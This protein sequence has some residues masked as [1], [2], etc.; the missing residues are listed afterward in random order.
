MV[1]IRSQVEAFSCRQQEFFSQ[2]IMMRKIKSCRRKN[3][4]ISEFSTTRATQLCLWTNQS[5]LKKLSKSI[6]K[7]EDFRRLTSSRTMTYTKWDLTL[8]IADTITG[9]GKLRTQRITLAG[10][11]GESW[12]GRAHSR[13]QRRWVGRWSCPHY[14]ILAR[15][16]RQDSQ[17]LTKKQKA[18]AK[19]VQK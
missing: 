6:S 3:T 16:S 14:L 7:Q 1:W 17:K 5:K 13:I 8:R 2:L 12:F 11:L 4:K 9:S 15:T 10:Y 19:T 18:R